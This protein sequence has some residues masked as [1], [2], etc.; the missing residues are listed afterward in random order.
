MTKDE[1]AR[2]V[3]DKNQLTIKETKKI[4]QSVFDCISDSLEMG[5]SVKITGFGS[6]EV[7]KRAGFKGRHPK[8]KEI[9]DI[10]A[11]NQISFE[12][13]KQLKEK[14]NKSNAT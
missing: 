4:V 14:V 7:R 1:L 12:S 8:S 10:K 13:S 11:F 9:I 5:E 3:A 6:F 2:L